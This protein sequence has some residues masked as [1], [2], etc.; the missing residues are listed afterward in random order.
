[1]KW[2]LSDGTVIHLGGEVEGDSPIA[3]VLRR[4]LSPPYRL[5]PVHPI[6][7]GAV[8]LDPNNPHHLAEAISDATR[9]H[10]GG[11][12]GVVSAPEMPKPEPGFELEPDPDADPFAIH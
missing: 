3:K 11:R 2:V 1:M 6:P 8:P 12:V 4:E 7:S 10:E 5:M 9:C